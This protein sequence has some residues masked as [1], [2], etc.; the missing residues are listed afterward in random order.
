MANMNQV[1]RFHR[2]RDLGTNET[3]DTLDHWIGQFTV[4]VQRDPIMSPFLDMDWNPNH[5]TMGFTEAREGVAPAQRATNCKLFLSHLASFLTV[6]YH[7][8]S[9]EK[10]TTN[11]ESVWTLLRGIYNVEKSTETLLDIGNLTHDKA[12]SYAS[13]FHKLV[14]HIEMNLA[15]RDIE[16]N[17]VTTGEDGDDLSV[18]LLDMAALMWLTKIDQRLVERVKVDYSVQIKN[19]QRLS[20]LVPTIAKALPGMLKTMNSVKNEVINLISEMN[21]GYNE[22]DYQGDTNTPQVFKVNNRGPPRNNTRNF[23][24]QGARPRDNISRRPICSHCNWLKT[25]LHI[26]EIDPYHP[27]S[28]CSRA[29]PNQVKAIIEGGEDEETL[30]KI[31]EEDENK[32]DIMDMDVYDSNLTLFQ[33]IAEAVKRVQPPEPKAQD[34]GE[35][36]KTLTIPSPNSPSL[37]ENALRALKIRA[38]RLNRKA[39]SPKI[40][41]T[42]S[43]DKIPLHIDEGSELNCLD[44][45]FAKKKNIRLAPSSRTATAAGN[46]NLIILGESEHDVIVD[47]MFQSQHVPINLGRVT[48][49]KDLGAMMILGEPGKFSNSLSTDAKNRMVFLEQEG[50]ILSKPYYEADNKTTEVCRIESGPATIFPGDHINM[51]VPENFQGKPVLITPRREFSNFFSPRFATPGETIS[52][53]NSSLAPINLKK[54]THVADIRHTEETSPTHHD[55]VNLVHEHTYDNFKFEPRAKKI[56]PP[57][58]EAIRIDPD[59]VLSPDTRAKFEEIIKKYQHVSQ[60]KVSARTFVIECHGFAIFCFKPLKTI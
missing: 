5:A 16:V 60:N 43:G 19:G 6:P 24:R 47:T 53:F 33:R 39:K 37:S 58:I 59:G 51:V 55:S 21:L 15:P 38:L 22:D 36:N 54:H 35:K 10:R 20:Q 41:V 27:T 18:T 17:H 26:K 8:K 44:G 50:K 25:Y 29:L 14:Y 49:I 9:I 2:P 13:F 52:L 40:L 7:K 1:M 3:A 12:E 32:G 23:S 4:Y 30:E 34:C 11:I 57:D 31:P 28:S 45:D 56:A 42:I 48:V 46:G